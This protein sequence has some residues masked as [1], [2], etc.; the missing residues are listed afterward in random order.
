MEPVPRMCVVTGSGELAEVLV[1]LVKAQLLAFLIYSTPAS[2]QRHLQGMGPDNDLSDRQYEGQQ[3]AS[4]E[5]LLPQPCP[6]LHHL[7]SFD[8]GTPGCTHG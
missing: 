6:V 5:E 2:L 1:P 4:L 8:A 3:Q 7:V